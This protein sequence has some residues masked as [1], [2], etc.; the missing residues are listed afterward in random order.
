MKSIPVIAV[1][2]VLITSMYVYYDK[3]VK[4]VIN[5]ELDGKEMFGVYLF[6]TDKIRD[7]VLSI[8]RSGDFT[9]LKLDFNKAIV[10]FE[11]Q[12]F[13]S[14]RFFKGVK[15]AYP[16]NMT[17]FLSKTVSLNLTSDEIPQ[18]YIFE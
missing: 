15:L 14:Y 16:V 1:A 2:F 10:K 18:A 12:D 4:V 11:A 13:G 7:D 5:Y 8:F 6:G 3:D 17:I 9:V